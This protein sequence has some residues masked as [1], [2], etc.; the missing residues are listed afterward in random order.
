L[1]PTKKKPKSKGRKLRRNRGALATLACI[2]AFSAIVRIGGYA[3][4]AVA[5]E[6][7]GADTRPIASTEAVAPAAPDIQIVLDA[8]AEREERVENAEKQ[9]RKRMAALAQADRKIEERLIALRQAEEALQST[10]ALA[11]EAAEKDIAR[12]VAVYENMKPKEAAALFETME[13][14]FA[15]GFLGR[16]NPQAAAGIMAGLTP[17]IAHAVSVELA[18][19]NAEVPTE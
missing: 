4:Q 17:D 3:G 10:L 14:S 15:A 6:T 19:R 13:P 2:L 7:D 8:L 16:M 11:D 9:I 5:R 18:G 1:A 12:L